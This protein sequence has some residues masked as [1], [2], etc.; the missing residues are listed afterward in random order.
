VRALRALP[1]PSGRG[2]SVLRAAGP[3]HAPLQVRR[4]GAPDLR[5]EHESSFRACGRI[6]HAN[7]NGTRCDFYAVT[8]AEATRSLPPAS[9]YCDAPCRYYRLY[10]KVLSETFA[11]GTD[12]G[13]DFQLSGGGGYVM[14]LP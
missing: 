9:G 13:H 6:T 10:G 12:F 1:S 4:K 14:G 8:L 5:S 11:V 2:R 7:S 3:D